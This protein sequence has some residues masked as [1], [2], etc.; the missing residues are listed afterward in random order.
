MSESKAYKYL[1]KRVKRLENKYDFKE[2]ITGPTHDQIDDLRAFE[3]L[4]HA[5]LE[6]YFESV[7][8]HIVEKSKKKW[9]R[10]HSADYN[11]ASLFLSSDP[12]QNRKL[13]ITTYTAQI[14]LKYQQRV[15]CNNGIKRENLRR[16]Y[17]PLGFKVSDFDQELLN[18]LDSL[19]SQRGEF[20]HQSFKTISIQSKRDIFKRIDDIIEEIASFE[21][22]IDTYTT[23]LNR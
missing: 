4:C 1:K 9:D 23:K 8:L 11:L 13:T 7:A 12:I 10:Y 14:L 16:L 6:V 22:S 18:N 21:N 17:E 5:E 15:R 20:A 3:L 19:G 2:R